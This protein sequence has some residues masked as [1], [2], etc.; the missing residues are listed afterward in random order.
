MIDEN[1]EKLIWQSIDGQICREDRKRIEDLMA[2]DPEVRAHYETVVKFARALDGVQEV[3]PPPQLRPRILEAVSRMPPKNRKRS[4][5][6]RLA[7]ALFPRGS[8]RLAYAAGAGVVV[9]I[10]AYHLVDYRIEGGTSLDWSLL[11]GTMSYVGASAP[12]ASLD[13][14]AA[15]VE[16]SIRF[17]KQQ[18]LNV[19][20][21]DLS[22]ADEIQLVVECEGM[23]ARLGA[24]KSAE[25]SLNSVEV[26]DRG[27]SLTNAGR[28]SYVL[29]IHLPQGTE[30]GIEVKILSNGEAIWSKSI[31]LAELPGK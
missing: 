6:P 18:S 21:I 15:G 2:A 19:A 22:S 25:N 16:G 17:H 13:I 7:R 8:A 30:S 26:N 12:L 4:F 9:G 10:I 14:D 11:N 29:M 5:S 20:E 31:D 23:P 1:I 3:E 24:M 28:G 27:I